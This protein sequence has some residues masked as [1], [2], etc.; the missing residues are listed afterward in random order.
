M[1]N[2]PEEVT[3]FVKNTLPEVHLAIDAICTKGG[4][5]FYGKYLD[6][7]VRPYTLK[8]SS[9]ELHKISEFAK[10]KGQPRDHLKNQYTTFPKEEWA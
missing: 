4:D 2:L 1:E 7:K 9:F 5:H 3:G 10:F 6:E 8:K